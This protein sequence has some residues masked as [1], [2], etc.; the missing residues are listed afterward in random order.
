MDRML[1]ILNRI[2]IARVVHRYTNT[3]RLL[4][5][6]IDPYLYLSL[7]HRSFFLRV[8]AHSANIVIASFQ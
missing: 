1:L 6:Y 5:G 2:Y 3:R 4:F 8:C 7:S